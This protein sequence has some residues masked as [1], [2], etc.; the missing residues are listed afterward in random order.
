MSAG[1]LQSIAGTLESIISQLLSSPDRKLSDLDY[2]SSRHG[3]QI[4]KWQPQPRPALDQRV[5]DVIYAHVLARPQYEAVCAWDGTFTYRQLWAH[6]QRLARHLV[7]AGVGPEC[8]VPLA[9]RKSKWFPVAMLAVL[10]S[11]GAFCPLDGAQPTVRL[12]SLVSRL[13]AK[14]IL[15]SPEFEQKL[16]GIAEEI[17]PIDAHSFTQRNISNE[18]LQ[19]R[20]RAA[21]SNTAYVIWTSGSTGEPK[22][23]VL[24]HGTFCT[25]VA[26]NAPGLHLYPNSRVLQFSHYVFDASIFENLI[27]IMVG[28]TV[29][30]PSEESRLNG[31]VD[32]VNQ[33]R[34]T[35]A[36]LTPS[37]VNFLSPSAVPGLKTLILMGE[38]MSQENLDTWASVDL[39]N[40]Y[41][42]AECSIAATVNEEIK[43][44]QEP[45]MIGRGI[46]VRCW[47]T[48]P[49]NDNRLVPPGCPGELVIEGPTLAREYIGD[50]KRTSESFITNPSWASSRVGESPRRMYK[51]G[52]LARYHT[53]DGM[54][55][56][57]GRKDSQIK[58]HGQRIELGE[59][60]HH[61]CQEET[62]QQSMVLMPKSGLCKGRL[63]AVV[64]FEHQSAE[65]KL[66]EH[67][68]LQLL[69]EPAY[70]GHQSSLQKAREQ[71]S[72]KLP[73]FMLPSIWLVVTSIPLLRSGKIDRKFILSKVQ[74][75]SD[76][77][78]HRWLQCEDSAESTA[79]ELENQLRTVWGEVLNLQASKVSLSRSFLSLGGDSISAMMVQN[80]CKKQN[81]GMT[82]Q[83]ILSAKSIR[84]LARYVRTIDKVTQPLETMEEDFDLSPIQSLFFQQPGQGEGHFNQSFF[85]RLTRRFEAET[86]HGATK[87]IVNRH[88]ML[89]ARFRLSEFDDEWK[90]RITLDTAGSYRFCKYKCASKD[91]TIPA[92][93]KTQASLDPVNGPL[94]A[95]DFF[96]LD[97]GSQLI[98]MTGHHLVIDLVSWRVILQDLEDILTNPQVYLELDRPFSF[99]NWSKLQLEHCTKQS[100]KSVLPAIEIPKH[101][102]EYWG[103]KN[104]PNLYGDVTCQRFEIEP[105]VTS[106]IT[107]QYQDVVRTDIV[108]ILL[109]AM[110]FSFCATFNDR[111]PP[112]IYN[113][114]HGREVWD[115]SIDLSRTVGWFTTMYPV[116]VP[117]A[118]SASFVDILRRVKDFRRAVPAKGR[119]YFAS[120]MLTQKGSRKFGSHWP[121]EVTFN[122]LGIYQQLE[123]DGALLQP[124]DEM[125]GEARGA[126]GNAD[127][128]EKAPRFGFFEVSAVVAQG[129]LR[130]SFAFSRKMKHQDRIAKWVEQCRTTLLSV[131]ST[132]AQLSSCPTLSDYPLLSTT[133]QRL[134]GFISRQMPELGISDIGKVEN[135][136][137]CSQIQQGLLISTQKDAGFYAIHGI[138]EVKPHRQGPLDAARLENAWQQVVDRHASLRTI[139]VESLSQGDALYDQL[140]FKQVKADVLQNKQL[141]GASAVRYLSSLPSLHLRPELPAHRFAIC[142]TNSGQMYCRLDISHTIVDGASMSIIFRDIASFYENA[143][144]EAYCPQYSDYIAFLQTQSPEASIGY[145]KSYLNGAEP[146]CFPI[147]IDDPT[148][149]KRKLHSKHAALDLTELQSFCFL[150]DVTLANLFHVAWA[151]TL[152]CYTGSKDVVFGY[153]TSTRDPSIEG[154]ENLVGYLVNMLLCR[155]TLTSGKSLIGLMKQVQSDLSQGQVHCQTALSEVLHANNV[156]G[157][158]L[159]DTTLSYRKLPSSNMAKQQEVSFESCSPY[160]DP[161]EY[162]VSINIEASEDSAAIDLDYWTDALSDGHA[163]NV[164][165]TFLHAIKTITDKSEIDA[166]LIDMMNASD[167]QI[168]SNWNKNVPPVTDK[169]V[170]EVIEQEAITR[171]FAPAVCGWDASFTYSDLDAIANKL[172][173]Y[174]NHLGVG[175]EDICCLCFEK[176]AFTIVGMLGVLKAGA[177][178]CSLDPMHPMSALD[179]RI[180]DTKTKT[181]LT[182]RCYSS[183]FD[184]MG[185]DVV[186]IDQPFLRQLPTLD[187]DRKESAHPYNAC[188][189]IYTSGSTGKPKGVVLEHRALVTSSNAHGTAL[190]IGRSS[191]F[192]QFSSYTFDNSLEEIFTSLMRGAVVC[193][194]SDHDRLNDLAGAATRLGANFM[195]LTPTLATYLNPADMPTIKGMAL[196]GEALTKNALEVWGD[197]VEIH[198]QYG[199]SECSINA[200]HRTNIHKSSDPSSIGKSVGSVSWIVDPS[201]HNRLMPIGCEGELLIEG[202]ILSRGYLHDPEKTSKVFIENPSWTSNPLFRSSDNLD[203][204]RMYKTGDLVRYN[205]DGSMDYLGRKDQQVKLHGQ[206]IELGEIEYHTRNSLEDEW[207]FAIELI[208]PGSA[209]AASKTLAVF[210]CPQQNSSAS[211]TTPEDG[212]LPVSTLLL[213]A[214]RNLEASLAKALPKHMVPSMYIPMEKLPL[215]TS[216]KLDRKQ[217]HAVAKAMNDNQISMYRLASTSVREPRTSA[218]KTLAKLWESV[219]GL[220]PGSVGVDAQ[221]LRMG[222]DSIAAIRLVTAA[223]N[224]GM[225]LSVAKIFQSATLA[226]MAESASRSSGVGPEPAPEKPEPFSLLPKAF[227]APKILP[228]ISQLCSLPSEEIEDVYPC[229]PIQE[230]LMA[231][232]SKQPG[233]YLAQNIY[234]L[235]T[236][237]S[238]R[239]KDAWKQVFLEEPILRTRIVHTDSLGFLQVVVQ[240]AFNCPEIQG[241]YSASESELRAYSESGS[242]LTDFKLV[243]DDQGR[244]CFSWTIH[245]A[246]FD[247]WSIQL[248]LNKVRAYYDKSITPGSVTSIPYSAYMKH[249]LHADVIE[250]GKFWQSR[251]AGSTSPTFPALPSPV[252]QPNP[253]RTASFVLPISRRQGSMFTMPSMVRAAWA[254]AVSMYTNS[255]DVVF[256]ETIANRDVPVNGIVDLI[257][258]TFATLPVR[259]KT[260]RVARLVDFL[261]DIQK[262]FIDAMPY[263]NLGLQQI[264]RIDSE[265]ARACTFQN[266]IA[267]NTD[268]PGSEDGFWK[269]ITD[270]MATN[271]FFTYALTLNFDILPTSIQV[272]AHYDSEI[273]PEWQLER[274]I[275]H[276]E[277]V[278][279]KMNAS[280]PTSI[281]VGSV[282]AIHSG[283]IETIR[284]WNRAPNVAINH[285]IHEVIYDNIQGIDTSRNAVA[286]WDAQLT[287]KKLDELSTA[288]AVYLVELGVSPHTY[289]PICF[290]KSALTIVAMLAILKLGAAFVALDGQSP[291]ARLE[292]IVSDVEAQIIV[293]STTMEPICKPLAARVLALDFEAILELPTKLISLPKPMAQDIAYVIFTSGST[294][295][296]KGTLVSHSAFVSG[297]AAHGPAMGMSSDSRVLQFSSYTFDAC[298]VEIFTTLIMGG[299]V[300]VPDDHTRLNDVSKAIRDLNANWTLL[301]PSFAQNVS[302]SDVPSL[303]TLVLGGEAMSEALISLWADK[304]HLVN[305]YGP[306]ECA[307]VATVQSHVSPSSIASNIGGAVGSQAFIVNKD[308]HQELAPVGAIGEL[309]LCGPTLAQGYLKNPIKTKESFIQSPSWMEMIRGGRSSAN[310]LIYKTGD[311]VRYAPDGTI[312]FLGRK[313]TQ[314]KLHGQRLELG[315]IEHYLSQVASLRHS[316]AF[317]PLQGPYEKKLVGVISPRERMS[318]SVSADGFC[319]IAREE[320]APLIQEVQNLLSNR[321]PPYMVPNNWVV[322]QKIPLMPSGKLD[323]RRMGLWIEGLTDATYRAIAGSTTKETSQKGSD[324]EEMIRS[325]WSTVLHLSPEQVDL[326]KNFLYMGGDSISAMQV[327]SSARKQ[328]LGLSVQDIIRCRSIS[329]LAAGAKLPKKVTY[330]DEEIDHAFD[331]SPMQTLFFEWVD[332]DFNHF[333]QSVAVSLVLP[334]SRADIS[335][336]IDS[337]AK[338]HSML[339]ARFSRNENGTWVQTVSN[340]TSTSYVFQYHKGSF[341][342]DDIQSAVSVSQSKL[343]VENG[344]LMAVSL[345]EAGPSNKQVLSLV[346]H[347]LIVDVMSWSVILQD[348][349]DL[350]CSRSTMEPSLP[351]Q[352]WCKAQEENVSSKGPKLYPDGVPPADFAFWGMVDKPNVYGSVEEFEIEFDTGTTKR[353]LE[354][355]QRALQTEVI[356]ILL[357]SLLYSFCNTFPERQTPPPIF[358]E[359]HGRESWDSNMDLTHTVGWFTTIS[360][361]WIPKEGIQHL[362]LVKIVRWVKDLRS[363]FLEKG[364]QYFAQRMLTKDGRAQC[365]GHWPIEIA[366][367]YLGQEKAIQKP[368][369]LFEHLSGLTSAS[370]IA[371]TV[372]RFALIETSAI[373]A[374]N[375]LKF[376]LTYPSAIGKQTA[377][378]EWGSKL[379]ETL[380]QASNIL[381][382]LASQVTMSSFPSIPLAYDTFE[383]LEKRVIS[384]GIPSLAELEDVYGC[385]P[386]QQGILLSQ[387]KDPSR[388]MYQTV[389]EVKRAPS[390]AALDCERLVTAWRKVVQKHTALRTVFIDSL[391]QDGKLDQVVLRKFSPKILRRDCKAGLSVECLRGQKTLL[392]T[393]AQ[394]HHQL[395]ICES[396]D[397][398]IFCKLELSHAICDGTSIPLLLQDLGKYYAKT[399]SQPE[400]DTIYRE[401]I[402]YLQQTSSETNTAFWNRYLE[403][404][405]PCHLPPQSAGTKSENTLQTLPLQLQ[406]AAGLRKF[407]A[408]NDVTLST[409]LQLVWSIVLSTFSGSKNICFGYL[410]SGRDVPVDGIEESVGLFISMLVCRM[411][412]RDD[413]PIV[414]ALAQI[415]DDHS[416]G[417]AHQG[418]SIAEMQHQLGLSG[419]QLFNTA[420][421]FQRRPESDVEDKEG[422]QFEIL[423]AH[424]PGEYDVSINVE[425]CGESVEVLLNYWTQHICDT[426]ASRILD[427][428]NNICDFMAN[429]NNSSRTI[430]ETDLCGPSQSQ[431]I[432]RWNSK[433]L[434]LVDK[435]VHDII[436]AQSQTLP[437]TTPAICSWDADLTYIKLMSLSKRLGK[438]LAALGAGSGKYIALC[439]EKSSWAVVAM[440]GV[441]HT[442][443]AFVPIEPS[444]PEGRIKFIVSNI[445]AKIVL[446]SPKYSEKF[447]T[448]TDVKTLVID[449]DIM[450]QP[451]PVPDSTM[452]VAKTTDPAYLIFTSGTTGLPKGT[453]ISHRAFAT[454]AAEHAPAILMRQTSRV[455]QFSN[456]CFDASIMEILT[457]LT[458]GACVCI[459]S[460]EERMN[461][462]PGAISRMSVN[463]TLLTPSVANVLQPESCASLKVLVTGGEAMQPRHIAKWRDSTAL[464]NAYGPSECSVI[465][466]TSLKVDEKK[467]LVDSDPTIIGHAV[468]CRGWVVDA[469]NH[470]RLLPIGSIGELVLEGNTLANGYLNN[471]E[472]TAKAFVQCPAWMTSLEPTSSPR[473]MYKTGDLVRYDSDGKFIYCVRK[474]TQ[475]KLNGLRIE[476][477]EIEYHVKQKLPENVSSAVAMVAPAGQESAIAAFFVSSESAAKDAEG[478]NVLPISTDD[479]GMCK[480]LKK[481]L[482]TALPS[483]MIPSLFIPISRIPWTASGKIDQPR[484]CKIV[485]AMSKEDVVPY[486]LAKSSQKRRPVTDME[487]TLGSIWES[488]LGLETG[489][490]SLDDGFFV[491]GG[492][493]VQAMRLVAAARAD[494]I[495]ISTLDIFRKPLLWEMAEACNL[496]E[497]EEQALMRPF[498]LLKAEDNLDQLLDEVSSQC[499]V[500]KKEVSDAYPCSALQ[501][502]LIT[503]S[504]KQPGA[505]VAQNV[506][507]LPEALDLEQF[508]A[509][510]ESAIDEID[511]LRTRVLHTSDSQFLQIVLK[512]ENIEWHMAESIEEALAASSILPEGNG[513]RLLRLA[514]VQNDE[515]GTDFVCSMH[516]ALYDGWSLP[517]MLQRV[518]EIYFEDSSALPRASYSGFMHYLSKVDGQACTQFWKSRFEGLESVHFPKSTNP[519]APQGTTDTIKLTLDLPRRPTGTGITLPTMIR[520]AWAMV[521]FAHTGS[522]D[523][524]FG[525]VLTGRDVPVEGIID[526]LGP[527]LTTVPTRI[528]KTQEWTVA[529]YLQE[530]SR[531]AADVIPFQHVG[532][533]HIRRMNADTATACD[534]QN[535]LVIQTAGGTSETKIWDAPSGGVGSNF[536]TYPLVVE[537]NTAETNMFVDAHYSEHAISEWHVETLLRQFESVLARLCNEPIDSQLKM[538]EVKI[539]SERDLA[540]IESWNAYPLTQVDDCIHTLFS[541]Q[542]ASTPTAEAVC[543]WDGTFTYQELSLQA[544]V[545]SQYLQSIGVGPNVLVPFCMDKSKWAVV[546]QMGILLAGGAIVPLDPAHPLSRHAEIMQDTG[547]EI[548][549]CSPEYQTKY[550][551]MVK[552]IVPVSTDTLPSN[553]SL[554]TGLTQLKQVSSSDPAYVIFTSGSTGKPKGVV[555]EHRAFCS[556][557]AAYCDA[558]MMR[559][560]ARVFNFASVT[561]DVGLME[562]LS[563]LTMGACVCVPNNEMKMVNLAAAINSVSATWA[564][565]TPSVAN[566][567]EPSAVPTLKILVC[568]G[569]AMSPDNVSK[570]ADKVALVNGYG[571]TEASVISIVNPHVSRD[572]DASSIGRS[573]TAGYAW[574]TEANDCNKLAPLGCVG[575]LVLEGPLL[576]REYLHDKVKTAAAF[577]EN[578]LWTLSDNS[579]VTKTRR[580]YRTGDLAKFNEDGSIGFLG[581]RDNQVKL[582]GQRIELGEIEHKF[583]VHSHVRHAVTMVPKTGLCK[584]RL[585]AIIS[586]TEF[587]QES[588]ASAATQCRMLEGT[589]MDRA[590]EKMNEVKDA[591]SSQ[592]PPYMM[593][594]LYFLVEAIPLLVSGKLD[595]KQAEKWLLSIDEA[596]YNKVTGAE[597]D[598]ASTAPIT[599]TVQQLREIWAAVFNI[600]IDA[601]NPGKSFISQGGDSLISMS[602]IAKCRKQGITLSLQEILQSKSLFQ[603]AQMLDSRGHSAGSSKTAKFAE[604]LDEDFDLSPVQQLY[605]Q[606]GDKKSTYNKETR[607]NQ[608]QTFA[609]RQPIEASQLRKAIETIVTQH[610]MFRARF[611]RSAKGI[612][613]QRIVGEVEKSYRFETHQVNEIRD[614]TAIQGRS[615]RGLDIEAGPLMITD[616]V[617]TKKQGQILSIIAHHLVID[618]VS[619]NIILQQLEELLTSTTASIE[620][621]LSFQVWCQMQKEHAISKDVKHVKNIL[622][623]KVKKAD[624]NFW[625]MAQQPNVYGDVDTQ[626]FTLDQAATA[627]VVGDANNALGTQPLEIFL[628]ALIS[629][630]AR[631]FSQRSP[632]AIFNESHGRDPWESSIDITGTTGWFTSLSP[633]QVPDES[634]Q[635]DAVELLRWTKDLRRSLPGNGREYFAH[636]YLTSDGRWR[637]SDHSP[638]E[639]LLNYTGQAQQGERQ[640]GLFGPVDIAKTEAEELATADVGLHTARMALFEISIG[641][642]GGH[643]RFSFM[644]NKNMQH[645]DDIR[646]WIWQTEETL[647]DMTR[648]LSGLDRKPTLSDYP[649]LPTNYKGLE[650]HVKETFREIGVSSLDEVE[651]MYICAPTQEGLLLSQIRNPDQYVNFVISE[652]KLAHSK[653]RIDVPRLVKSWQ[654]VVDRHQSLRTAFVYSVCSG[655][656]FDQISLKQVKGGAKVV[657]CEDGKYEE[658]L[659][660]ISLREVNRTRWPPL[661]HQFSI[662]ISKSGNCYLKLE[663]NHAVIDGGSGALITRD[664]ALA[665]EGQLPGD[666]KPLYSDYVRFINSRSEDG[667]DIIFWRQ[668]LKGVERCHLQKLDPMSPDTKQLNCIYLQFDRFAE[669]GEVCRSNDITLSNVMLAAWGLVMRQYTNRDDVCFGN[670]TAGRDAPVDGI[671]DTVG[672]FINMLVCRI[673]FDKSLQVKDVIRN[674]QSDYLEMLPHQHCSLAKV[675]HDLGLSGEPLFNTAVSIQNQI[676][677]RD[678]EREYDALEIE[679]LNNYDPTE[680]A[681]TVNIRSAPG[682]EGAVIKHWTTHVSLEQG[683]ALT[684]AYAD[685]LGAV[686]DHVN[687]TLGELDAATT[688]SPAENP[689]DSMTPPK[690]Q[691]QDFEDL[692]EDLLAVDDVSSSSSGRQPSTPDFRGFDYRSLVKECVQE[693]IQQIVQSGDIIQLASKA[694]VIDGLVD[695]KLNGLG[696]VSNVAPPTVHVQDVNEGSAEQDSLESMSRLLL[697]LWSPLL[698]VPEEKIHPEDSFFAL[699]GDSI[700]AM[701]LARSA[702][703]AGFSLTVADIFGTPN[704][705]DMTQVLATCRRKADEFDDD[706]STERDSIIEESNH[707][708]RFSLLETDDKEAF[709]KNYI[710]P[711]IGVF[712][713]GVIDAFPVTDFQAFSIAGHFVDSKWMLNHFH[714]ES[715]G[716]LDLP[717][718]RKSAYSLVDHFEILRTVFVPCGD[719]FLQ[720]VLRHCRPKIDIHDT[721]QELDKFTNDLIEARQNS[722]LRVEEPLVKI[723]VIRKKRS[724]AHRILLRLSHAQYDGVSL[725]RIIDALKAAYEGRPMLPSPLFSEFVM[726][727][728]GTAANGHR[729]YW[730]GLLEGSSMTQV[731]ARQQPNYGSTHLNSSVLKKVIKVPS[732]TSKNVTTATV[733][734]A[735]WALTLG[736]ISGNSDIIFGNLISGRNAPVEDVENMVGPSVNIVPVRV[737][738]HPHLTSLELLRKIQSQQVAGMAFE[739]LGFRDI[740]Q[741]CTDWPQWTYFSSIVQHQN[742]AQDVE[743]KLD[744]NR[745]KVG[746]MGAQENLADLYLVTTPQ[747]GDMVEVTMSFVDDGTIPTSFVEKTLESTCTIARLLAANPNKGLPSISEALS[748]IRLNA[749]TYFDRTDVEEQVARYSHH[750]VSAITNLLIRGW[751]QTLPKHEKNETSMRLDLD[752][753]FFD[754]GGDF[755]SM[756]SLTAFLQGKEYDVCLEDLIRRPTLGGQLALLLNR[757]DAKEGEQQLPQGRETTAT[758][759]KQGMNGDGGDD[760]IRNGLREEFQEEQLPS[761]PHSRHRVR[762]LGSRLV[763]KIVKKKETTVY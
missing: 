286:G 532:L 311:L 763:K 749:R 349:E 127:V 706:D 165:N 493:S 298:I 82:V 314:T 77:E 172:A 436:Y 740:I 654:K 164:M 634:C 437:M 70:K 505:Y 28:A 509:A 247:G 46:G 643:A 221:F 524:V 55:F 337:L 217:L 565:L 678:A 297:A 731:V 636:R 568:G 450:Q 708:T 253:T 160:Y 595:R 499:G 86:L 547:A 483:Y 94:F 113:E 193:V 423:E 18:T 151:M 675:Q 602:I 279:D 373:V 325:I 465:A 687:N 206:R 476:L 376:C 125:A 569:E 316:L 723:S 196:G 67:T 159:F 429:P 195:D 563:P 614:L 621:P 242:R 549:L 45:T 130:F 590:Q 600:P 526:I 132:L 464:V 122:Y 14:V 98:F 330:D 667:S 260:N 170:H 79:N 642:S 405:E 163:I 72:T 301:T 152:K 454:S 370:D 530:V 187:G 431:Q 183:M 635:G 106:M 385:S 318:S 233:A 39:L 24:E 255:D 23:I 126:G 232:S 273:L 49:D 491:L 367:N 322:V 612:W 460:D 707:L 272:T 712:R 753:S 401:Y 683:E 759:R 331:L 277:S 17:I 1:Y 485:A 237:D 745:Y 628:A 577:V 477:G 623:F 495:S 3:Q 219:L 566:L 338:S 359:G 320:S 421:T 347:H 87:A 354:S 336:A 517:K 458:V 263:H 380:Q 651:D 407:C 265:C 252:Y 162:G 699:G 345:F 728:T 43:K 235:T 289:V 502:G 155:V 473:L 299:C 112:A 20:C 40:A 598:M 412:C 388:Y 632:P 92:M 22:G 365:A 480:A 21:P 726:Q 586:L 383:K 249:L 228:E 210:I 88:S 657:H 571:P 718:L 339:R 89:R 395:T 145:W 267:I 215:T 555:V 417:I 136:Y 204:R 257:G 300:C 37:V 350:L 393:D 521:L 9:F 61:L 714:F 746:A 227:P 703:E 259:V 148:S 287:Y 448:Y 134:D 666:P 239:L 543:A 143:M 626:A 360:P 419:K 352:L 5:T 492:D 741:N 656:A 186:A 292:S 447:A 280:E 274:L 378:R 535:L 214:F 335:A 553:K 410:T 400:H 114:G 182:S 179:L 551:K 188:C 211:A 108:D 611:S 275:S 121:L 156:S 744:R 487:K 698:R 167:Q 64:T 446:C 296:P 418:G 408:Q 630:F 534:F 503:L 449:E 432:F 709:I 701:E 733:F 189:V 438:H 8:V 762:N 713:G 48:D 251:L 95:T 439:F 500:E 250:S 32:A 141:D 609:F 202:P 387:I 658:E 333:N 381:P 198:N 91:E 73:A 105:E 231:L 180:K 743:L 591:L 323:R 203:R 729:D 481:E 490:V 34:V 71:L 631:T 197:K 655:H 140:V 692:P 334:K 404:V 522:D 589:I 504:I 730:K 544:T 377:L 281:Q 738:V 453:I 468:G 158:S 717:R 290:E 541:K 750:E 171:P 414:E 212:L 201:D 396:E 374:D 581:R 138:Y 637:F 52:D 357:G 16:K 390:P 488:I 234:D 107:S 702:R 640:D 368:G 41:G 310:D 101:E 673:K 538:T 110:M 659:A 358:N 704:F 168:V 592:L 248:I 229:T 309:V 620:K 677:T 557:S 734:K 285:C 515:E 652:A 307:V 90:Q 302:P 78:I 340:N 317:A 724:H 461:N 594:A 65:K 615:Q 561:F 295:K 607:F 29:C 80:Q 627:L 691:V 647:K 135:I 693:T 474:D 583:E 35:W 150:H 332:K 240:E 511:I 245:H 178:F 115:S 68:E 546:A 205:S 403:N 278:I 475:I 513:S 584:Q 720:V 303:E 679:P 593:P 264:M 119:P 33:M 669:L 2:F 531:M 199:P 478:T 674:L 63:V 497:D 596:T 518:E 681:V 752:S 721:D 580:V 353:I 153:L 288:L 440:L 175:T 161:T 624:L 51:T 665:Y 131:P 455:L 84:D 154:V 644:Y 356:D 74:Q 342:L 496:L 216:G 326:D 736:Q 451:L 75:M 123:R 463:W 599:E 244:R 427:T 104:Q 184:G 719:K 604:K 262:S 700:L 4:R 81:L 409:A 348:L 441:L 270:G 96:E 742:L 420:F 761:R 445:D 382:D 236:L 42:P 224:D 282:G 625:G 15:C 660:K 384:K 470:D 567:I 661:P 576:A 689:A 662:C 398:Q 737:S 739:S 139:F 200:T 44:Y 527:T 579:S 30:I 610:S 284:K 364:R 668:Y 482:A 613:R 120:R 59:I 36:S 344:P 748:K 732:L 756:A 575:E 31:L 537:C 514:L 375:K 424:D 319:L 321:L 525:E 456:L 603:V 558:M 444:H 459:P 26:G 379:G 366:F 397:K 362:D 550:A 585:V 435:R 574:I 462:I 12:E 371:P 735:A 181:I 258:P 539:I 639:V 246:L 554:Q 663:L 38:P 486:K 293:C 76:E 545:L 57:I 542:V 66:A 53:D 225:S 641:I 7:E 416:Q 97:D 434:P 682:D 103:M 622:P 471:E 664:L 672:A 47:L 304:V 144:P 552:Q 213:S 587:C 572:K 361:V 757:S 548:I 528:Q 411:D 694:Q 328:G 174:L 650:K 507:R 629:S 133:Y 109:S 313:D 523:V 327:A 758:G 582:H 111:T 501:E 498:G 185:L 394:P 619:W 142:E 116:C 649:L 430:G 754:N 146:C 351:F 519:E 484:L 573:H 241:N 606:L 50:P 457:T 137:R 605:F 93:S 177:A 254:L 305:A 747:K 389:F 191:R 294:G 220:D 226:D 62:F 559:P 506:F 684:Q 695:R 588:K 372:P 222:G 725:P 618:V 556:S 680:Y 688:S 399:D 69:S 99:Q 392:F 710:C 705:T 616:L 83:D 727:A 306:S 343:N 355:C 169:C 520:A 578:P 312:N 386:M 56:F 230:G 6:A 149:V 243:L 670:L 751:K 391:S 271:D 597:T 25:A 510:W 467:K 512:Q 428:F 13:G 426:H 324:V 176:S 536:F 283:D 601:V 315:E 711:Q 406:N 147:L 238:E 653:A 696:P 562:N 129:K 722:P 291:Q 10:E 369:T 190:G 443:A 489:A 329:H 276:F 60:E 192:L 671:Q 433:S 469:N 58:L 27:T 516:H 415:R 266:L 11:G 508:K 209:T 638:I 676:S 715:E 157:A 269:S 755:I 85:L 690:T 413:R 100:L 608:S 760:Q 617:Q 425:A 54:L 494:R 648:K 346:L 208:V 466:T 686:L 173:A 268:F 570:W 472:K 560:D 256:G 218:E 128:G 540:T 716:L 207:H 194:P 646:K 645:Q 685:V 697:S 479:V 633:I 564:F 442:G 223:R 124:V 308:D 363:R 533:Q 102:C 261:K 341:G 19:S 402:L 166:E 452:Q 422:L 118:A 117:E 529:Q